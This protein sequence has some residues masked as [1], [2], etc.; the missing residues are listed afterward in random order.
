M[1]RFEKNLLFR[2]ALVGV[3]LTLGTAVVDR[4]GALRTPSLPLELLLDD[5][6]AI[7]FQ[8]FRPPPTDQLIHLDIDDDTVEAVG[9]PFPRDVMAQ[10]IG[11][12]DRA[13][14]KAVAMDIMFNEPQP[15]VDPA[16]A[17]AFKHF[18]Q[19]PGRGVMVPLSVDIDQADTQDPVLQ[20]MTDAL[21]TNLELDEPELVKQLQSRGLGG[22]DL[23]SKVEQMIQP[24]LESA[25]FD[26]IKREIDAGHKADPELLRAALLPKSEST[27]INK[28]PTEALEKV[29]PKVESFEA[30]LRFTRP[31]DLNL[32][33]LSQNKERTIPVPALARAAAYSAFVDFQ[34]LD[35][36]KV[37]NVPLFVMDRGR[38]FPQEGMTL[39][40][41]QLGVNTNDLIL[42]PDSVTIP[43]P[44]GKKIVIPVYTRR[45]GNRDEGMLMDIPWFGSSVGTDNWKTMYDY[46]NHKLAKQHLPVLSVWQVCRIASQIEDNNRKAL[47]EVWQATNYGAGKKAADDVRAHAPPFDDVVA[48]NQLIS[49]TMDNLPPGSVDYYKPYVDGTK[50]LNE[51]KDP[52]ERELALATRN[53]PNHADAN[54]NLTD[55]RIKLREN[56]HRQLNGKAVL[57]GWIATG[58]VDFRTT[59]LHKQ[60][61]GVVVHGAIFN[62]IMINT[63]LRPA[64]GWV[65][66]ALTLLV[67]FVV[68]YASTTLPPL[69]AFVSTILAVAAFLLFDFSV[70][71]DWRRL[72]I[73]AAGPATAAVLVW[74][75]CTVYRFVSEKREKDRITNRFR[76]YVDPSLVNYVLEHPEKATLQGEL[77]ELSVVFT[78]LAGFTTISELLKEETVRLLNQYLGLMEPVI[79]KNHG[80]IN[81]FLGD[82]IMFFFGAPEPYPGDANLHA[83]AAVNTVV[84]MQ[85][86]MIPFNEELS[87]R[88]LPHLTM[89]AGVSTGEMTVGDAG[90]PTRSDYTVLGDRVNLASRLESA[91][92]ATGT[93]LLISDR[94]VDLLQDRYLVRPIG[95]LQVVGKDEPV[96]TY[97]PLAPIEQASEEMRKL[98]LMTKT[99]VD[100]YIEQRFAEC[101]A[102]THEL[103]M[104]FGDASQGK[105]C[106][107]YR[108][109]SMEYLRLPPKEFKGQIKLESK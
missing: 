107:L 84:E 70:A 17:A 38:V 50:S 65:P 11:E 49:D 78:D 4:L 19:Q 87:R 91:N 43:L 3:I 79:R 22:P 64:A 46:P 26:R 36:A 95:R 40:C 89:R 98:V 75:V 73:D 54:T 29:L 16:L 67:G 71:Y 56:L 100:A 68:T 8:H 47:E 96:M 88:Q 6:R 44:D 33:L 69:R 53:L 51:I 28:D 72:E 106:A 85:K 34:Q 86:A 105:L 30:L 59:P 27:G 92:K 81:K 102:A 82:G 93:L 41:A 63:F 57:M 12:V 21:R 94:T 23:A 5:A 35:D 109:L 32:E 74:A 66:F 61:P 37:R 24:A 20:A 25:M 77:R 18:R 101:V 39:A 83:L 45:V 55:L 14:A 31:P 76:S 52:Q 97:E 108:R 42:T 104:T 99:V 58:T 90:T 9:Y 2:T 62:A 13:G 10:I 15:V 1:T 48:W 80:L 60:C 103:L 7:Y